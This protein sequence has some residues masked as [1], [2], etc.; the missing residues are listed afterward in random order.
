MFSSAEKSYGLRQTIYNPLDYET[1][2]SKYNKIHLRNDQIKCDILTRF[3]TLCYILQSSRAS[4]MN[5][6]PTD[7]NIDLLRKQAEKR[8]LTGVYHALLL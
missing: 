8:L 6:P 3:I 2:P 7:K 1:M 5:Y 4:C